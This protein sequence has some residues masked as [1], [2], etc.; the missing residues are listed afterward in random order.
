MINSRLVIKAEALTKRYGEL[1]AVKGL[2]L[3]VARHR[4]T[5]F[6]GR[7][8]AGKSSTLKKLLGMVHP[9]SGTA[10]VLGRRINDPR[11][12]REIRRHVAYVGEEKPLYAYM[13]V[14]QVIR[15]TRSFYSDWRPDVER[16]LVKQYGL[17]PSRAVK[18]LSKGMRTKLALLL[19]LARHPELLILDEPSE[20]LDPVSIEELLHALVAASEEGTS[21][22]FSTH[23]IAEIERIADQVCIIDH[24]KL[25]MD[26]PLEQ[27]REDYRCVTV[28]FDCQP[29]ESAFC[30]PGIWKRRISGRQLI[31]MTSCNADAVAE[32]AR[33]LHAVS[34]E[35]APVSL[36]ELFLD[37]VSEE[38]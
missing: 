11:Q 25:V 8:G 20:G 28:G 37:S 18:T 13:T 19:A 38:V 10:T 21:V 3:E 27:M 5:G 31:L 36:R 14:G 12:N 17:A 2:N 26:L 16:M 7:N 24:G 4:I 35:I 32:C 15:F 29:P 34:V 9:S 33:S 6:L 1:E 22:F 23:Q 30:I